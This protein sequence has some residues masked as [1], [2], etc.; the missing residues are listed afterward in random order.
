MRMTSRVWAHAICAADMHSVGSECG[1]NLYPHMQ[2][3]CMRRNRQAEESRLV[4]GGGERRRVAST[5]RCGRV[6]ARGRPRE[7]GRGQ[8]YCG[9]AYPSRV[10]G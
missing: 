8:H 6:W 5:N 9:G 1:T 7:T 10:G 2:R 3:H 4:P